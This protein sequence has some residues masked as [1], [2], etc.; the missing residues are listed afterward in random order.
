MKVHKMFLAAIACFAAAQIQVQTQAA[1]DEGWLTDLPKALAQ[2]K[3]EKKAVL[4]DFTGSDWCPPCKALPNNVLTNPEFGAF[5]KK[6]LVLVLA[7]FPNNKPQS[8]EMKK[9]NKALSEKFGVTAFPT[10][11]VLDANGRQLSKDEGYGGQDAKEFVAK[12][13][14]LVK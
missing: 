5:A 1:E 9:S 10:V 6:H 12:L 3:S 13:A 11:I 7:D 8:A 2:A 4:I 14:K